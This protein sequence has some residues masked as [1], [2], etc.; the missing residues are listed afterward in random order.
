MREV[1]ESRMSQAFGL[2][3]WVDCGA[4]YWQT[5]EGEGGVGPASHSGPGRSA[6]YLQ[7]IHEAMAVSRLDL[8]LR[9]RG[10]IRA[11]GI[12]RG[13]TGTWIVFQVTGWAWLLL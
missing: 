12:N 11:R 9:C 10:K 5:E 1:E 4:I 6:G 7:V 8:R 2:S 3:N 13:P